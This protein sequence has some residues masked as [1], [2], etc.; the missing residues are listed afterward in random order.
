MSAQLLKRR[1]WYQRID[2]AVFGV[3]YGAAA[4]CFACGFEGDWWPLLAPVAAAAAVLCHVLLLLI[5][6]WY[7]PA[8]VVF[9]YS[10]VSVRG[11]CLACALRRAF[12]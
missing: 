9:Q 7:M 10:M 1:V 4:L 2:Y 3:C 5:Q 6:V 8:K 11:A 12:V